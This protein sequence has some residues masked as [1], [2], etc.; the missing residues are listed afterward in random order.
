MAIQRRYPCV[1]RVRGSWNQSSGAAAYPLAAATSRG[2]RCSATPAITRLTPNSSV[3]D[4]I[5]DRTTIP[6]TVAVAGSSD[7]ISA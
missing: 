7:T 2:S 6:I 1:I 5:W 3:G 4:G